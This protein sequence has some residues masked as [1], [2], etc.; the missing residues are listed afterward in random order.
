MF[1]ASHV[2]KHVIPTIVSFVRGM[3]SEKQAVGDW[4]VSMSASLVQG[5][6][7]RPGYR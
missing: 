1:Q 4:L 2:E 3:A 6:V 7:G 5:V